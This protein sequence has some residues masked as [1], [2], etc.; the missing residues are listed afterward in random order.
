MITK[1]QVKILLMITL[2]GCKCLNS[3]FVILSLSMHSEFT[4][5]ATLLVEGELCLWPS[6]QSKIER[7]M[8]VNNC[9]SRFV[10]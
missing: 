1:Y 3:H 7:Y 4:V 10:D 5:K 9:K 6:D 8:M 2:C